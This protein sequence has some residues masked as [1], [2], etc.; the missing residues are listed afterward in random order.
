MRPRSYLRKFSLYYEEFHGY[1]VT[2]DLFIDKASKMFIKIN[3]PDTNNYFNEHITVLISQH[4]LDIVAMKG[5]ERFIAEILG[6]IREVA[7]YKLVEEVGERWRLLSSKIHALSQD[8]DF[9]TASYARQF[10]E[11]S[12]NADVFTSVPLL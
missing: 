3:E 10:L 8:P 4:F 11:V 12:V 2:L 6:L 1:L 7:G 5:Y 9:R